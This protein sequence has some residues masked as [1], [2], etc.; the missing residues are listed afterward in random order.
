MTRA[1]LPQTLCIACVSTLRGLR[2]D[3]LRVGY[4]HNTGG[5]MQIKVRVGLRT[6]VVREGYSEYMQGRR[7]RK[8]IQ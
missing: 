1:Y 5:N 3:C 6:R 7:N 4:R 8:V 2:K